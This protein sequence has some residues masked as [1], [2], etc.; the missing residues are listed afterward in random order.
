MIHRSNHSKNFMTIS[1]DTAREAEL[2]DSAYHLLIYMLSM[3]DDWLFSVK[4]ISAGLGWEER[5]T[6]RIIA[7]L[8]RSGHLVITKKQD[9]RGHFGAYDWD[10]YEEPQITELQKTPNSAKNR[11][12]KNTELGK[13][14]N[15]EKSTPIRKPIYIKKTNI[16]S[17]KNNI[18]SKEEQKLSYGE[19]QNVYLSDSE[20]AKLES[21]LG[22]E[23]LNK[24]IDA[25]GDYLKVNPKKK[26]ASHYRTILKWSEKERK[27]KPESVVNWNEL[28]AQAEAMDRKK[29]GGDT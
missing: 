16:D 5:K 25:L 4:G 17:K 11:T 26:Y 20:K 9:K 10:L 19:F 29:A 13:K 12:R 3:A 27:P 24:Y 28:M 23:G 7:E 22:A 14:P 15:S 1:N 2:S 8:K 18:D 6:L 21:L